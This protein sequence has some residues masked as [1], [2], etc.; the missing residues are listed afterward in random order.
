M[1]CL[2]SSLFERAPEAKALFKRV[3]V[4][5]FDSPEFRAPCVRVINGLDTIINMAFDPATL[6]EHLSHLSD[7]HA[8]RAGV[9]AAHFDVSI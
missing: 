5:D 2:F 8:A 9:K 3:H 1:Y 7:Q 6:N 4:D